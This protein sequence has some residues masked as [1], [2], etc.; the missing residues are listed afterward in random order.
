MRNTTI[1]LSGRAPRVQSSR[2]KTTCRRTAHCYAVSLFLVLG[3]VFGRASRTIVPFQYGWRFHYGD[4]PTSP[5]LAGP[6]HCS[7]AFETNLNDYNVCDGMERNPNRFSE[8]DCRLACCYDRNCMAWQTNL[9]IQFL[10]EGSASMLT[11]V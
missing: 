2:Q 4:D 11:A 7:T 6:G 9:R 8:K 3:R 1:T 5:P 10:W